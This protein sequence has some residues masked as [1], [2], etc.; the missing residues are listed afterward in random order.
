MLGTGHL[1]LYGTLEIGH[2]EYHGT[3]RLQCW[4]FAD[5]KYLLLWLQHRGLC[6]LSSPQGGKIYAVARQRLVLSPEAPFLPVSPNRWPA[7]APARPTRVRIYIVFYDIK[8]EPSCMVQ[9]HLNCINRIKVEDF[10][11]CKIVIVYDGRV[12]DHLMLLKAGLRAAPR[13]GNSARCPCL[14]CIWKAPCGPGR[15]HRD[16]PVQIQRWSTQWSSSLRP[17]PDTRW[18]TLWTRGIW[19]GPGICEWRTACHPIFFN[20]FDTKLI[21]FSTCLN[22][23]KYNY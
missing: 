13:E 23:L 8:L 9:M 10:K 22:G 12:L 17:Q 7:G 18:C 20:I 2:T 16:H 4:P 6:F 15:R 1:R 19:A 11:E 3:Q 14:I 5:T 21:L